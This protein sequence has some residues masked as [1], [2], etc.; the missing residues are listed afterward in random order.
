MLLHTYPRSGRSASGKRAAITAVTGTTITV[1]VGI[2]NNETAEL[3]GGTGY[4]DGVYSN[5][6]LKN[7]L[8]SGSG[9]TADI[10]VTNGGVTNVKLGTWK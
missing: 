7:K 5:I 6:P 10:T 8:G 4:S 3:D 1:N 2:S 9:A